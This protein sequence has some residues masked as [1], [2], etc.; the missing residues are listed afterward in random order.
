M[1]YSRRVT[2]GGK[3]WVARQGLGVLIKVYEWKN[4]SVTGHLETRVIAPSDRL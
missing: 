2:K 3:L 1:Q 4:S